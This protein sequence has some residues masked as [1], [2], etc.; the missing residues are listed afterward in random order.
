MTYIVVMN[1]ILPYCPS[2]FTLVEKCPVYEASFPFLLFSFFLFPF[3][4]CRSSQTHEDFQLQCLLLIFVH[5]SAEFAIQ[6][7]SSYASYL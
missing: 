6:L 1:L 5:S 2:S 3:F 4:F 7:T